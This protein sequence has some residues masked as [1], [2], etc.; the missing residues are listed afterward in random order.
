MKLL[1][2]H[3][4]GVIRGFGPLSSFLYSESTS[5]ER[6]NLLCPFKDHPCPYQH[7]SFSSTS[8]LFLFLLQFLFLD[9]WLQHSCNLYPT[10]SYARALYNALILP[11]LFSQT[12]MPTLCL[13]YFSVFSTKRSFSF[14]ARRS[15]ETELSLRYFHYIHNT[16]AVPDCTKSWLGW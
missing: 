7:D 6:K 14:H 8:M 15:S 13:N 11:L 3:I 2:E 9:P 4:L 12:G 1:P 10:Y 5:S 16:S